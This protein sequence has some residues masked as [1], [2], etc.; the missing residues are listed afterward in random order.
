MSCA[1]NFVRLILTGASLSLLWPAMVSPA[2]SASN[3]CFE[4]LIKSAELSQFIPVNELAANRDPTKFIASLAV[5]CDQFENGNLSRQ[6]AI[7]VFEV[8][9]FRLASCDGPNLSVELVQWFESNDRS[10]TQRDI[11]KPYDDFCLQTQS[12]EIKID[13]SLVSKSQWLKAEEIC[14]YVEG[15]D[16]REDLIKSITSGA[17]AT[18]IIDEMHELCNMMRKNELSYFDAKYRLQQLIVRINNK[19]PGVFQDLFDFLI[20]FYSGIFGFVVTLIGVAG[21][22]VAVLLGLRKLSSNSE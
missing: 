22:I 10:E 19:R 12:A 6:Q 13:L 11:R 8:I 2:Y 3:Q 7:S 16:A 5:I 20:R 17:F 4:D 9:F 15:M 18:K 14:S 1:A 21:T